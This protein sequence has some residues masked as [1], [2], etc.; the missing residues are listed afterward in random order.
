MSEQQQT[1]GIVLSGGAGKRI[2]GLDKGLVD[3]DGRPMIEHVIERLAPQVDEIVVCAHRNVARYQAVH[4]NVVLDE[5]DEFEGPIAGISAALNDYRQSGRLASFSGI[6]ITPCDIP[7]LA[8]DYVAT[9]QT[10]LDKHAAS[11]AVAHDGRRRQNLHCFISATA[12]ESLLAFYR[13]GGRAM[14]RWFESVTT[15]DVDFSDQAGSFVN[16]NTET[17]LKELGR[18]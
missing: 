7:R 4:P 10:E 14:H 17:D 12:F 16:I 9:L 6:A 2:G 11:C 1:L 5:S 18:C 15:V 8:T 13:K 3:L